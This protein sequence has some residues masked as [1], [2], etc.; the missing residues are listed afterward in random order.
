[1]AMDIA[2]CRVVVA[3]PQKTSPT[4]SPASDNNMG[5]TGPKRSTIVPQTGL[6]TSW[7]T[8]LILSSIVVNPSERWRTEWR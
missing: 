5:R 2:A 7:I 6:V 4:V 3:N 1:M 8:A